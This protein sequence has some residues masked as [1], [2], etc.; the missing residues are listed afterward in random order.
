MYR[1]LVAI[2]VNKKKEKEEEWMNFGSLEAE[3]A[4]GKENTERK[5]AGETQGNTKI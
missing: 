3:N 2:H 4:C 1:F 5:I